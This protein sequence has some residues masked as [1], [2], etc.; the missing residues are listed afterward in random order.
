MAERD[1]VDRDEIA[2]MALIERG[3]P[4]N[5][6][7][8]LRPARLGRRDVRVRRDEA[9][10]P[11]DAWRSGSRIWIF[12][13]QFQR[14]IGGRVTVMCAVT[15]ASAERP[16]RATVH[17]REMPHDRETEAEAAELAPQ[18]AFTLT[19]P[20]E[21]VRKHVRCDPYACVVNGDVDV[22]AVR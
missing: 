17:F 1:R 8:R 2:V 16:Y 18:P 12:E 3:Y 13:A 10:L 19:E 21:H 15:R 7:R 11:E 22:T 5:D 6:V 4:R 14:A 9:G 20:L